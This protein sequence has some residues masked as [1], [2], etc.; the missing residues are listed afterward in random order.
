MTRHA[1]R[2]RPWHCTGWLLAIA[3]GSDPAGDADSSSTGVSSTTAATTTTAGTTIGS[4]TADDDAGSSDAETSDGPTTDGDSSTGDPVVPPTCGP[5]EGIPGEPGPHVAMIEALGADEWLALGPPAADPT[6]GT[7]RGRSWGG[8]ALVPAPALRGAF[9]TGEGVHAYVK[10]DGYGMDDVWFYDIQGHA[11]IPIYPG[12]NTA[13]FTQRVIDGELSI[14]ENGQLQDGEG[15]PVPVHVLIH[16]WDFLTYDPVSERFAFVA[17][18]GMGR[19]YMPGLEIIE[20]GLAMLEQQREG[21]AIPPMSPW[22]WSV[23]DCTWERYPIAA[24]PPDVG[25]F[26]AFV[27]ASASD[28]YVYAGSQ[29]V[30]MFDRTSNAWT[31]VADTG[32]RPP[33]Y[34]HGVA[35]DP[36]RHR[37]YMGPGSG[38][39]SNQM[40][41]YDI[42][43]ATWTNPASA[44]PVPGGLGTNGVSIFYDAA[45]DIVTAFAYHEGAHGMHYTYDPETDTWTSKEMP[46]GV[47]NAVG[48]PSHNAFYDEVLNAYFVYVASDSADNGTMFAYRHATP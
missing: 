10:P 6:F 20:E 40:F 28:E 37:L 36:V 33:G 31:A 24:A 8:R 19:Y 22:F 21:I 45:N 7:A 43:T 39:P 11:W 1:R 15:H 4:S 29:G 17:G 23:A 35:Y 41:V 44:G 2:L 16:A 3:C 25:G 5:L 46:D 32:P 14:D 26:A 13:D 42:A 47:A 12:T 18:D 34:D 9:F 48:Y 30:A 27:Y 38:G